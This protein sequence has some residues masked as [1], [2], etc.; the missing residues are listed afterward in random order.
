VARAQAIHARELG[1]DYCLVFEKMKDGFQEQGGTAAADIENMGLLHPDR[2]EHI[3]GIH[4]IMPPENVNSE[5]KMR[6]QVYVTKKLHI[7]S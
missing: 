2:L 5:T 7:V 3:D 4:V 6:N 1:A